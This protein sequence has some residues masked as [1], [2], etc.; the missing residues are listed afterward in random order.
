MPV[1]PTVS[2]IQIRRGTAALWTAANPVLAN[3][4][5]GLETDT[6]KLK[7]G[8][9]ATAWQSLGYFLNYTDLINKPSLSKVATSN[10]YSDLSGLPSL[11]T[12]ATS[13]SYAD[14]SNKPSF[15]AVATSGLY[16]DLSSKPVLK[17]VATSGLYSDLTGTPS[18][19][20]AGVS[21]QYSD[22]LGT[23]SLSQVATT[24]DYADLTGKPV[25]KTVATTANYSDLTGSPVLKTVATT[26]SYSDLIGAPTL[27]TVATTGSYSD[28]TGTPNLQT[29]ATSG[30][31]SDLTGIPSGS[32][33]VV[34]Y[35]NI[36][37]QGEYATDA[38]AA[39]VF[40][41][42]VIGAGSIGNP[43]NPIDGKTLRWRVK[44]DATGGWAM[45]LGNKFRLPSS[46]ISAT[47]PWST[48]P[49]ATDLLAATYCADRDQWDVI[50][51]VMGY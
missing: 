31:Y 51:F 19:S 6:G 28:L 49:N 38:S 11:Q 35:P 27:K 15:A 41:L 22:L 50:A 7:I 18:I 32:T 43:T 20:T 30:L 40:D 5:L 21:G 37:G 34:V 4:E 16:A 45:T 47:L 26:A 9:G 29:V 46:H 36:S 44:Q 10:S 8:N 17:T 33:E 1:L 2:Q 13:G 12:V 14:L 25:L 42:T 24:G 23:P 48:A 3:G 39:D